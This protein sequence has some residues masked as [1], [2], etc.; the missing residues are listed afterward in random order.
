MIEE[1]EF[2]IESYCF[3]LY[4]CALIAMVRIPEP[5]LGI[6][7]KMTARIDASTDF[8]LLGKLVKGDSTSTLWPVFVDKYGAILYR[9]SLKW[10][11]GTQDAE[12][13]VQEIL[14][15]VFQKLD[16]Y[17]VQEGARFRGWLKTV[18][19]HCWLDV[20]QKYLQAHELDAPWSLPPNLQDRLVSCLACSDLIDQFDEM[21]NQEI[22]ALAMERVKKRVQDSTW[23]CFELF[24]LEHQSGAEVGARLGIDPPT[25]FATISRVR[26]AIRDEVFLIEIPA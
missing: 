17:Q 10:G 3:F 21:A 15:R 16:H 7:S 19:Y 25:V 22:L 24:Y 11:S 23:T 20:R 5:L 1:Q 4:G 6:V 2:L 9:W 26:K 14:I 18:A 13:L 8:S 12:D